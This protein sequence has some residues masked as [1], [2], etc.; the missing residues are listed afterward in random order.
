MDKT[1]LITLFANAA[2]TILTTVIVTRISLGKPVLASGATIKS[3]ARK[4]GALA[5]QVFGLVLNTYAV[6]EFL[7]NGKPITKVNVLSVPINM[8]GALMFA[9]GIVGFLAVRKKS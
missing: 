3:V 5:F 2:V 6:V 4:Y 1:S 7:T 9:L 8:A